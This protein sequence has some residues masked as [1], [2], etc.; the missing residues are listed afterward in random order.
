[1]LKEYHKL[2]RDEIPRIIAES[3]KRCEVTVLSPEEYLA[4][5]DRKLREELDEYLESGSPE[6]LADLLEVVRAAAKARGSSIEQVEEIRVRKAEERGG[7]EK[8]LCLEKVWTPEELSAGPEEAPLFEMLDWHQPEET[9]ELGRRKAAQTGEIRC[10]LQPTHSKY[11]KNV[12]ANCAMILSGKTDE[13]L[14]PFLTDLMKWLQDMNWPG[15]DVIRARLDAY[16]DDD[17]FRQA[18]Q[19]CMLEAIENDDEIWADNLD[20]VRR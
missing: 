11:N 15:A 13:E 1:M 18:F 8:R 19:A 9:Q 3:G 17:S 16:R 7:F 20:D 10:F 2:V 5:V 6:E 12:W 4:M 14:R